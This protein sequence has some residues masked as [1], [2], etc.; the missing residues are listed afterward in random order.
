MGLG[1]LFSKAKDFWNKH[2]STISSVGNQILKGGLNVLSTINP[3]VG[4]IASTVAGGVHKVAKK[5][6]WD[7]VAKLT[8][9]KDSSE[10][11]FSKSSS[12]VEREA[13]PKVKTEP[14]SPSVPKTPP[15][16][17][18]STS[19]STSP[20]TSPVSYLDPYAKRTTKRVAKSGRFM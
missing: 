16:T 1:K 14:V 20:S 8:N 11:N 6:G 7:N 9:L 19:Q 5:L 10:S 13:I 12:P 4:N 3:T 2:A 18:Q 15:S 17:S